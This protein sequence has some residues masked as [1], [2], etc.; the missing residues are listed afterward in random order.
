[1]RMG[2]DE[3]NDDRIKR[4]ILW[5]GLKIPIFIP[6]SM[7]AE[8]DQLKIQMHNDWERIKSCLSKDPELSRKLAELL[9]DPLREIIQWGL[10]ESR[11]VSKARPAIPAQ[12]S[13]LRDYLRKQG[14]KGE[15]PKMM[16]NRAS[17]LTDLKKQL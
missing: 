2:S 9:V 12:W 1:M 13:G 17:L 3:L 14:E 6:A 7:K 5:G 15:L 4:A 8:R 11:E 16:V 10:T